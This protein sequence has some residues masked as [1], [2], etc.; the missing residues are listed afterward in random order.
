MGCLSDKSNL[1]NLNNSSIPEDITS[2]S[3]SIV[4][5][6]Y[7][8]KISKGFLIKLFKED[9]EFFC[10][11]TGG[12]KIISKDMIEQKEDIKF[13]YDNE[14]K[15]KKI[16]L[17]SEKRIIKNFKD[18]GIDSTVIEILPEDKIENDFFLMPYINNFNEL[19]DEDIFI[20]QFPKGIMTYSTGKIKNINKNDCIH[21]IKLENEFEGNPIF[22]KGSKKVIGIQKNS[23]NEANFIGPIF[24]Y[25]QNFKDGN[26]INNNKAKD[27][28]ENEFFPQS[29]N[30]I[31]KKGED[32][33][34]RYENGNYY[35]GEDKDGKRHGKGKLYSKNG[36]LLYEGDYINDKPEGNGK[37]IYDEHIYYI[38]QFK[39]GKRHGK[40]KIY[41]NN[42]LAYEGDFINGNIEGNGKSFDENGDYYIGQFK[43][44]MRHG[45]G[46]L[47]DN[48]D[49]LM[50]EGDF[51]N[52]A[53]E[54]EGKFIYDNGNYY[55]GQFKKGKRHGKGKLYTNKDVLVFDGDFVND[56]IEG[57]GK[58]ITEDGECYY[59]GQFK[60]G[61]ANGKGAKYNKEGNIIYEGDYVNDLPDGTGKMIYEEGDYYIGEFKEGLQHG[62]GKYYSNKGR[63][64]YEGDFVNDKEE[65]NGKLF[66]ED[67]SY[68]KGPFKNGLRDGDGEEYDKNGEII[69]WV[70]YRQDVETR[71]AEIE[72]VEAKV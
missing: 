36:D 51:S 50:Y 57:N 27:I 9:V 4:N 25:F 69:R 47:Y 62:K 72:G 16:S 29:N 33:I 45:K 13:F 14:S 6:N 70:T 60:D 67:G 61:K 17:N 49:N 63:L 39:E 42:K 22:L 56:K 26:T 66:Y 37:R 64:I 32:G 20:I 10:L 7:K 65:G 19:K 41:K 15:I 46:K 8:D 68:F 48:N 43:E 34:I 71:S 31:G 53:G 52:G 1:T 54:G 35:I 12:E 5:I 28:N 2:I 18:I 59:I 44:N 3:K 55:I 40:G 23:E 38:G 30:N 58:S 24:N 11:M 21:T